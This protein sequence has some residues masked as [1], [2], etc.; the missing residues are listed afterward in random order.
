M[1]NPKQYE[2]VAIPFKFVSGI[3]LNKNKIKR[4]RVNLTL[5]Q[6]QSLKISAVISKKEEETMRILPRG[7]RFPRIPQIL[8]NITCSLH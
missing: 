7:G 3:Y 1:A 5:E 2:I 6:S 4:G 8:L